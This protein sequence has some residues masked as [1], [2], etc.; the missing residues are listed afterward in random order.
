MLITSALVSAQNPL[1]V[2]SIADTLYES[3]TDASVLTETADATKNSFRKHDLLI[4]PTRT[5]AII[6]VIITAETK[7]SYTG[8]LFDSNG[9]L[10]RKILLDAIHNEI[11][12]KELDNGNYVFRV[13]SSGKPETETQIVVDKSFEL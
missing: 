1:P 4:Y 13:F 8:E 2:I 5:S 10:V 7:A 6:N 3:E 9:N 12:L 11:N